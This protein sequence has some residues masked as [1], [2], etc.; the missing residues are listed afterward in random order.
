MK[1]PLPLAQISIKSETY[2]S[3]VLKIR[4]SLL[5]K[6]LGDKIYWHT[7]TASFKTYPKIP[8]AALYIIAKY[9]KIIDIFQIT[10]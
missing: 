4:G 8:K 5:S 10:I 9:I 7:C 6:F 3:F 1:V 2:L